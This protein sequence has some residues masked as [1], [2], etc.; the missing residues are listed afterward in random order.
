MTTLRPFTPR[1]NAFHYASG[2]VDDIAGT[3]MAAQAKARIDALYEA[4]ELVRSF[5][6]DLCGALPTDPHAA[7]KSVQR[8]IVSGLAA[9]LDRAESEGLDP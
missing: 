5:P 3:I 7:G 1:E 4:L 2:L 8:Q 9:L 6:V